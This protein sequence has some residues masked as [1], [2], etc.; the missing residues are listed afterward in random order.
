M[1]RKNALKFEHLRK[2][3]AYETET[4]LVWESVDQVGSI[5]RTGSKKLEK[6]PTAQNDL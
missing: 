5:G 2:F 1:Q 4:V 3:E 6:K